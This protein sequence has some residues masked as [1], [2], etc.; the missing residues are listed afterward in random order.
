ME[1]RGGYK[2][3][4]SSRDGGGRDGGRGGRD[5]GGGYGGGDGDSGGF[6]R[7]RSRP[8][9]DVTFDYKDVETLAQYITEEGKIVPG[10]VSKLNR[11]QQRSLTNAIKRARHLALLPTSPKHF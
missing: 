2:K 9:A 8:G 1:K 5:G 7:R 11:T 10:R 6:R 3:E 4:H